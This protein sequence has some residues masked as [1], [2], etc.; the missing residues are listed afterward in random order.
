MVN[1]VNN[2]TYEAKAPCKK[3][4]NAHEGLANYKALNT[5]HTYK[6]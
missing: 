2:G 1:K 5:R 4:Y 6:T 3:V